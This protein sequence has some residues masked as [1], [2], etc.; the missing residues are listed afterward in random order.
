MR[1]VCNLTQAIGHT[2][3][4][5]M[6]LEMLSF[7]LRQSNARRKH[8]KKGQTGNALEIEF[9]ARP[10]LVVLVLLSCE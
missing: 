10:D 4:T 6:L 5:N 2:K 8:F 1:T 7:V 9:G 3:V